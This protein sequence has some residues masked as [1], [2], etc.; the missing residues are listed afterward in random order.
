M[1]FVRGKTYLLNSAVNQRTDLSISSY[2]ST[3]ILGNND[4]ALRAEIE[5]M[6]LPMIPMGRLGKPEEVRLILCLYI[7]F[8][9]LSLN[10]LRTVLS[11]CP[12]TWRATSVGPRWRLMGK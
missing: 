8:F 3:A 4:P 11:S 1:Q 7:S 9:V 6:V 2:V 12:R 5:S 10:R